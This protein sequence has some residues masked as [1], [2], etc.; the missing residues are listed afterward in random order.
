MRLRL[1]AHGMTRPAAGQRRP[2]TGRRRERSGGA[3]TCAQRGRGAVAAVAARSSGE[4]A[5]V[6]R[7]RAGAR[8]R[9]AVGGAGRNSAGRNAA[10]PFV[11]PDSVQMDGDFAPLSSSGTVRTPRRYDYRVSGAPDGVGLDQGSSTS[12]TWSGSLGVSISVLAATVGI[13][14]SHSIDRTFSITYAGS[15]PNT[16]RNR[17]LS[18]TPVCA[19]HHTDFTVRQQKWEC[20][21]RANSNR[22]APHFPAYWSRVGTATVYV[23]EHSPTVRFY[24]CRHLATHRA[25][26]RGEHRVS[27]PASHIP[28]GALTSGANPL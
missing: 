5:G 6:G 27:G 13:S 7:R 15:W 9:R 12:N 4:F 24:H 14:A 11:D 21:Q 22:C 20:I 16:K 26:V 8:D 19:A 17:V 2:G 1:S 25:A 23:H 18:A 10:G 28:A 3:R